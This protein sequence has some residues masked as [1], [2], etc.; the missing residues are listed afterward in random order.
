ME[1]RMRKEQYILKE[2]EP[3]TLYGPQN[4]DITIVSWGSTRGAVREALQILE[5]EGIIANSLEIKY[6]HPFQGK[7]IKEILEKAKEILLVENNYSGQVGGLIAQ[8]TGIFIKNKLLKYDGMPIMPLEIVN[9][10]KEV[11][12]LKSYEVIR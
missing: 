5:N 7:E 10:A 6:L 1:K 2:L 8:H 3:P 11:L 4:A 9:K 12:N